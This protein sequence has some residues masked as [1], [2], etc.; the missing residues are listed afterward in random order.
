MGTTSME[1]ME[2]RGRKSMGIYGD[3]ARTHEKPRN[4]HRLCCTIPS[5][6][7]KQLSIDVILH[8]DTTPSTSY[9]RRT[10]TGDAGRKAGLGSE[11]LRASV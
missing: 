8:A 10:T 5:A 7:R 1:S 6:A 9:T 11:L 2:T 4:T 3:V